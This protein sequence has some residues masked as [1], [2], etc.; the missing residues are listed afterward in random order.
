M[1]PRLLFSWGAPTG[2]TDGT[3]LTADEINKLNYR[4][5]EDGALV[6]DDIGV[7]NFELLMNDKAEGTY[8]YTVTA[9]LYGLESAHSEPALVN[10]IRPAAPTNLIAE[11][12]AGS[13]TSVGGAVG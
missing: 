1:T 4:L 5:Y 13:E 12:V 6:V 9:V 8:S 2:R 7:L 3:Q 11:W 10:F